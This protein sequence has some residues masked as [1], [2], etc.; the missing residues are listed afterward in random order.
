M[1][2]GAERN[3]SSCISCLAVFAENWFLESGVWAFIFPLFV[4]AWWRLKRRNFGSSQLEGSDFGVLRWVCSL[5]WEIWVGKD[6]L[7]MEPPKGFWASLCNFIRFLPFFIGLLLLGSI[8]G[9][10][11]LLYSSLYFALHPCY[12]VSSSLLGITSYRKGH[13]FH[14]NCLWKW[15]TVIDHL[16]LVLIL[17]WLILNS[18][19][20][21]IVLSVFL[22]IQQWWIGI[23]C[24]TIILYFDIFLV[25][26]SSF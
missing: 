9:R 17:N 11:Q 12:S 1:R 18:Y 8:K 26:N 22:F 6:W 24:N 23:R 3:L 16:D 14:G 10:C 7:A 19:S 21:F 25:T 4:F 5:F 20:F 15:N 13:S 2:R